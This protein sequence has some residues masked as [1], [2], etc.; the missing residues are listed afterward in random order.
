MLG[1]LVYLRFN[2]LFGRIRATAGRLRQPK[3]FASFL[4]GVGY[5]YYFLFRRVR[6][7]GPR[8]AMVYAGFSLPAPALIG[9][10]AAVLFVVLFANAIY[11]A[12]S[13]SADAR[14]GFSETEIAFLFPAPL[15]RNRLVHFQLLGSQLTILASSILLTFILN[16]WSTLPGDAFSHAVGW[17]LILSTVRLFRNALSFGAAKL[18]RRY[19]PAVRVRVLLLLLVIAALVARSLWAHA[20]PP[21]ADQSLGFSAIIGYIANWMEVSLGALL[22]PTAWVVAPFVGGPP[23]VF[24]LAL[25]RGLAVP[26]LLYWIVVRLEVPFEEGSIAGAAKRAQLRAARQAAGQ[27]TA[28]PIPRR[29]RPPFRLAGQGRPETAFFW[30]NL[31][32]IQSWF[33]LR[34]FVAIFVLAL[35]IVVNVRRSRLTNGDYALVV[36]IVACAVA[37]YAMLLG[38]QLVRQDLRSDLAHSDLLKSY[39]LEG[40][41]IVLGELLTPLLLLSGILWFAALAAGWAMFS[42]FGP[43]NGFTLGTR[44]VFLGCVAV[45]IPPVVCLGLIIPNAAA[46]LFPAWHQTTRQRGGG[47]EQIGQRLIFVFGQLVVVLIALTPVAVTATLL[48]LATAW[49]TGLPA[50]LVLDT[51]ALLL[52]VGGEIWVG[53]WWLGQRF[54]RLDIATELPP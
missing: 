9:F 42:G 21:A 1:A 52:I 34:I 41:Q 22:A 25:V 18:L 2:S 28:R 12:F 32:G 39:P 5:V 13:A 37:F 27:P 43:A 26:F 15:T 7:V 14:L 19:G 53:L 48:T 44:L 51:F 24:A 46:L 31:I 35:A 29:R 36:F 8:G 30:K 50:A 40:W 20:R 16:R 17:W 47:V 11:I 49:K 4:V 38:P 33:N 10:G 3:Y 45:A 54:D 23:A 6:F